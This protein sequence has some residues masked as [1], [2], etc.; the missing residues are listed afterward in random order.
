M[1]NTKRKHYCY[2]IVDSKDRFI[3]TDGKL[4]FYW[5]K[6]V[7][8]E[9]LWRGTKV[10]RVNQDWL[11]NLILQSSFCVKEIPKK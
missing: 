6:K 2:V 10:L 7:A 9:K 8:E 5:N 1:P 4:P 3:I 11:L